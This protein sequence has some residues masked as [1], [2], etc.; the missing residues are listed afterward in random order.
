MTERTVFLASDTRGVSPMLEVALWSLLRHAGP[1]TAY[2]VVVFSD[3]IAPERLGRVR[4][5]F[6]PGGR[7]TLRVVEIHDRLQACAGHLETRCWPVTTWARLF[8][9]GWVPELTGRAVYLD[10]DTFVCDDLGALFEADMAGCA[11]AGVPEF[12]YGAEPEIRARL[13]NPPAEARYVNAGVLLLDLDRYRRE[14]VCERA[15]AFAQDP[16]HGIR[17]ADQ[18][19]LNGLL[20]GK[21]AYLHPRWNFSDG[22]VSRAA[23]YPLRADWWRGLRPVEAVEAALAPG[24][25]HFWGPRKPFRCNHRPEGWRYAAAMRELGLLRGALP[26]TTPAKRLQNAFYRVFHRAIRARLRRR[27]ARLR[28]HA[29]ALGAKEE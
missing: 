29:D 21:I 22:W 17:C 28:A 1:G 15:L 2:R 24:I 9:A 10:I 8:M 16:A 27:L 19:A 20:A 25:L 23:K 26:G 5:L 13:G 7:H 6:A 14:E 12:F 11:L 18:D 3:G 4:A